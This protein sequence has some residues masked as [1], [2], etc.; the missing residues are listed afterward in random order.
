MRIKLFTIPITDDGGMQAELNRFLESE[1]I[2]KVEQ[3]FHSETGSGLW[4]FC[5]SFLSG[6]LAASSYQSPKKVDYKTILNE[7]DFERFS[8]LRVIRKELAA[9]DAVPAYAIFTDLELSQMAMSKKLDSESILSMPGIANKRLEKY[10]IPLLERF[11]QKIP[12][13]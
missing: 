7:V 10:G 5:V 11:I 4:C 12:K 2:I 3:Q 9:E 13:S 8:L 6:N 1:K